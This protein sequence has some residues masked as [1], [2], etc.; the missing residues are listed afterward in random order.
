MKFKFRTQGPKDSKCG[1]HKIG[2]VTYVPGDVI[3]TDSDLAARFPSKFVRADDLG[4]AAKSE[5]KAKA[6]VKLPPLPMN[7]FG[8]DASGDFKVP[9]GYAVYH[10]ATIKFTVVKSAENQIMRL[11][12]KNQAA[13]EKFLDTLR[14]P[15]EGEDETNEVDDIADDSDP[16]ESAALDS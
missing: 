16:V 3:E 11:G 9:D 5:A 4:N 15:D 2:D 8:K 14:E 10:D 7:D 12:L 13:V 6:K 1:S